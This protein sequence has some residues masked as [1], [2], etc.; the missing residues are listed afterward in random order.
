MQITFG[1][2]QN[3]RQDILNYITQEKQKSDFKVIDIG[4]AVNGWTSNIIDM[5]VDKNTVDSNSSMQLDICVFEEWKKLLSYV[6]I[7]GM[8]DYAICTHTLEDVYNPLLA[9]EFLPKIVKAGVITMPS[10]RTELSK[11][12]S[13]NWLGYI[14]HRWIFD[15]IDGSI[16]LIPKLEL[17]SSLVGNS[18]KFIPEQEEIKYEWSGNIPYKVFMN[19]YLGPSP[20]TVI[21]SYKKL[22]NNLKYKQL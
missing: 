9:L 11:V 19:N 21:N 1:T 20:E 22:I 6:E 14:H 10:M 15:I 2:I 13:N 18:I 5:L 16:L 17:L 12:E 7:N 4:G 3:N 8:Y